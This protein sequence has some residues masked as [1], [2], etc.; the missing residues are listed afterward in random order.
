VGIGFNADEVLMMAERIERNGFAF[1]TGAAVRTGDDG[2]RD[3]LRQFAEM[4]KEHEA[5]F[6]GMRAQLSQAEK[7]ET[8]FDPESEGVKYLESMADT[9]IFNVNVDPAAILAGTET[10]EEVLRIAIG[11]EKD[12]VVF[13]QGIK[14]AVSEGLGRDRVNTVI[15]E[16]M[17]HIVVLGRELAKL[18]M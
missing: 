12:S 14:E 16:E 5:I 13:Y 17:W 18:A 10:M 9:R 6:A 2:L 11:M 15:K 3:L 7:A 1:Y 4:E 8:A